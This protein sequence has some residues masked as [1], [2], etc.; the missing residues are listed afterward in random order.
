HRGPPASNRGAVVRGDRPPP[1]R[2]RGRGAAARLPGLHRAPPGA[3]AAHGGAGEA[4]MTC[5]ELQQLSLAL[6]ALPA[7]DPERSSAEAHA[8]GCAACAEALAQA[9]AML[10]VVNDLAAPAP[11]VPAA[12]ERAA[13][14]A[15]T[16]L[17]RRGRPRGWAAIGVVVGGALVAALAKHRATDPPSLLVAGAALAAALSGAAL[18]PPRRAIAVGLS[19]VASGVL[20]ALDGGAGILDP[21]VRVKSTLLELLG[22]SAPL[23]TAVFLDR[24]RR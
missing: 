4:T 6:V 20:A 2:D 1:R 11:P 15:R 14:A 22:A 3:R 24:R 9:R 16:D 7:D 10:V 8:R 19:V 23:A 21:M 12:I 5:A 18:I 13:S 17:R